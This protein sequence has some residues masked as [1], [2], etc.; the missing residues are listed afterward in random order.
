L[1]FSRCRLATLSTALK[2][3]PAAT[4]GC[5][6]A[7]GM[8]QQANPLPD[9]VLRSAGNSDPAFRGVLPQGRREW[10]PFN[11]VLAGRRVDEGERNY[12]IMYHGLDGISNA[13]YERTNI[14]S[15]LLDKY[16]T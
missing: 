13:A 4:A 9:D 6:P 3:P 15:P 14:R 1:F 16:S 2:P 8:L 5:T 11:I 7:E 10:P 12:E